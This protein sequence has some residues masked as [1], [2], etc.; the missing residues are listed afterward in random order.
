V[1]EAQR[2]VLQ[3]L[4]ISEFAGNEIRTVDNPKTSYSQIPSVEAA[5]PA[6]P[7][8]DGGVYAQPDFQVKNFFTF[9]KFKV[10]M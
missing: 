3:A 4:P 1:P 5:N 9:L 8:V 2:G 7:R 6:T 10:R